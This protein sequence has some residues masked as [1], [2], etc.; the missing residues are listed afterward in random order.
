VLPAATMAQLREI[1][2]AIRYRDLVHGTWGVGRDHGGAHGLCVLFAG[3]PGT[4][5]TMAAGVLGHETGLGVY[6]VDLAGL[7]SKYIGETE[8]NL[9]RVLRAAAEANAIVLFDEADALFGRRSEVSDAH[10]RYANIE[11]AYLLQRIEQHGG[12]LILATNLRRNVDEAFARRI[13][14]TVE[15][16]LPDA[17]HR[18]RIWRGVLRPDVPLDDDLDLAFLARQFPIAGGE[19]ANVALSAAF[20]AAQDGGRIAMEHLVRAMARQVLKSGRLVSPSD[21]K[22]YYATVAVEADRR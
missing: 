14:H 13:A 1:A 19:I 11:V 10:D 22:Q 4:G 3:P 9:D 12:V 2:A 21:F 6:R 5:K 18:E 7:V 15:F 16:P 8:K 17:R 20:L